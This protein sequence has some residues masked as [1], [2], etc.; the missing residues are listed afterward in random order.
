M[1]GYLS[2]C[3]LDQSRINGQCRCTPANQNVADLEG[4]SRIVGTFTCPYFLVCL[5][6]DMFMK[7]EKRE[8]ITVALKL[9]LTLYRGC[10]AKLR[11]ILSRI[12]VNRPKIQ[13]LPVNGLEKINK[14]TK[15]TNRKP[16]IIKQ[17]F[18][19][20]RTGMALRRILQQ[21]AGHRP[22]PDMVHVFAWH[23]MVVVCG[24]HFVGQPVL[25]VGSVLV[26]AVVPSRIHLGCP[27]V[28][29]GG[30]STVPAGHHFAEE[31]IE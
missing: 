10:L 16:L 28:A 25:V 4:R 9:R 18:S 1:G 14:I 30:L 7:I 26:V 11:S 5:N 24:F 21:H 13:F 20:L 29:G 15:L 22:L 6:Q 12:F 8:S 31:V 3:L 2:Y 23:D 19:S 17:A 27:A